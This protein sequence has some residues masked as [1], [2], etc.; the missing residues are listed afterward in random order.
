[1]GEAVANV[2]RRV[3]ETVELGKDTLDLSECKLISFPE[4]I[5][6]L[7]RTVTENIHVIS[8]ANNEMKA[9]NSK[10][11][12]TF[13]QLRELNLEG[14]KLTQL[15]EATGSM[16][17][18]TSINLARNKFSVFPEELTDIKTLKKI[19]LEGNEITGVQ[20]LPGGCSKPIINLL[21]HCTADQVE[22]WKIVSAFELSRK[23]REARLC[24]TR[25][26][27]SWDVGGM[28]SD[29]QEDSTVS[30][31]LPHWGNT[32]GILLQREGDRCPDPPW[33]SSS[34]VL[35]RGLPSQK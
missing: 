14:N 18:L 4:G 31:P 29:L 2:A 32:G 1:M 12:T 27:F 6:K 5:Y 16:E 33:T 25:G 9:I 8:L 20:H 3:N 23:F 19:N 30:V 17:N 34:L 13:S 11:I 21:P 10:F 28:P 26:E 15:P 22:E 7:L 35:I 24:R